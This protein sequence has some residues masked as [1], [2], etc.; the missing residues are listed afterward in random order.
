M[1]SVAQTRGFRLRLFEEEKRDWESIASD[2]QL[3]VDGPGSAGARIGHVDAVHVDA[4]P[5]AERRHRGLEV[6]LDSLAFVLFQL[7]RLDAPILVAPRAV[8][9]DRFQG[10]SA[11]D[12]YGE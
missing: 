5:V 2:G 11:Q 9:P 7:H 3:G 6:E 8:A 10:A 12:L 4:F 1:R